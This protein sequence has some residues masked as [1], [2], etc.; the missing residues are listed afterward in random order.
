MLP[1]SLVYHPPVIDLS[2][3]DRSSL[4]SS[5]VSALSR[6]INPLFLITRHPSLS[7]LQSLSSNVLSRLS[8]PDARAAIMAQSQYAID[9]YEETE[10]TVSEISF[11][12]N[13]LKELSHEVMD[14]LL[15]DKSFKEILE[16]RKLKYCGK[17]CVRC[18]P[19]VVAPTET[20]AAGT[21]SAWA[22]SCPADAAA[23][24][25]AASPQQD[26]HVQRL[27]PH[28]DGNFLTL[29]YTTYAGL[30]VP[31]E[32]LCRLKAADV[33][34]AGLPTYGAGGGGSGVEE[35]HWRYVL[36]PPSA[37]GGGGGGDS[38]DS[39]SS[40]SAAGC[41]IV[42]VGEQWFG[43]DAAG[44]WEKVGVKCPLLHR[45]ALPST[46]G[47]VRLSVPFLGRLFDEDETME[48]EWRD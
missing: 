9:L 25:V 39:S 28:C 15:E 30:Q 4:R 6:S 33:R 34:N 48:G 3:P 45:V 27:G 40:S 20:T 21:L 37:G 14:L 17:V 13:A 43:S 23:A 47:D 31:D 22:S 41:I 46:F 16:E 36:P 18:Y 10:Y 26:R 24:A 38:T 1:P 11:L 29:L 44:T 32:R 42:S 5:V 7:L 8:S 2:S 12:K 35:E 19:P